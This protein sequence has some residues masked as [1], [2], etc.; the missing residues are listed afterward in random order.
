[1]DNFIKGKWIRTKDKLP[2][3]DQEVRLVR[4]SDGVYCV[5]VWVDPYWNCYGRGRIF[6]DDEITIT[7][8]LDF[9][10]IKNDN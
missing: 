10:K 7:H 1:M 4:C 2:P 6:L 3:L 8:W 5:A 9:Q